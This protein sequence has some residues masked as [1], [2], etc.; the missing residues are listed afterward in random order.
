[1]PISS[2]IGTALDNLRAQLV[3]R[4]GLVDVQVVTGPLSSKQTA[5]ESIQLG[6][7]I[8]ATQ[9]WGPLGNRRKK[10]AYPLDGVLFVLCPGAGEE[11]IKAARDRALS[12]LAEIEAQLKADPGIDGAVHESSLVSYV[13]T[14]GANEKGRYCGIAFFIDCKADLTI[15]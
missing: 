2:T 11:P 8:E 12:L 5:R 14:Q 7:E 9:A 1:M 6:I 4:P 10:E 15:S 13:V 3:A